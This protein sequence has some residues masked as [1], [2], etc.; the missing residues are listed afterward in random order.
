MTKQILTIFMVLF[1][2]LNAFSQRG[3]SLNSTNAVNVTEEVNKFGLSI[4]KAYFDNQCNFVYSKL[5]NEWTDF[6][7]GTKISKNSVP[8]STFCADSPIMTD[9]GFSFSDYLNHYQPEILNNL[10]FAQ[11]Y[12][13]LQTLL[14]LR[15]GDFYFG[16]D[17]QKPNGSQIFHT[18]TAIRFVIRKNARNVFEI[19]K[20]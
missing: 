17:I 8:Q 1:L 5:A 10:Q 4:V 6:N 2:G 9:L 7:S 19:T 11:K 20:I 15:S 16:G 18:P 3:S 14:Q 13:R 12:P